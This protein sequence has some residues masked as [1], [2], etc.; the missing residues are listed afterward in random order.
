MNFAFPALLLLL[1]Y[2]P[3]PILL[4]SYYGRLSRHS[5]IPVSSGSF[6]GRGLASLLAALIIQSAGLAI[7][8]KTSEFNRSIP[9]PDLYSLTTLLSGQ[10][11]KGD[12]RRALQASVAHP[13]ATASYFI[14]TCLLAA[15]IGMLTH[16]YVRRFRLDH[17][18]RI[19]RFSDQWYYLLSGE[20][21]EFQEHG[22]IKKEIDGVAIAAILETTAGTFLY[23]GVLVEYWFNRAG[24][25]DAF[26]LTSVVRRN[27]EG[28]RA[29]DSNGNAAG[30]W[31]DPRYYKIDGDIF[32]LKFSEV[33]NLSIKFLT[34]EPD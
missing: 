29:G 7:V 10:G 27:I 17:R 28:D 16:Y 8:T 4:Y 1:L 22:F 14:F 18:Y 32:V 13:V 23:V 5:E 2:L 25:P 6:T 12:Y 11:E 15:I 24:E 20:I 9:R 21:L 19:L 30:W 33:K 26:W 3:G 31:E 34:V